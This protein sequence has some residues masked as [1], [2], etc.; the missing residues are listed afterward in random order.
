L[1]FARAP[2]PRTRSLAAS[3]AR[4]VKG[5]W[6]VSSYLA[7]ARFVAG[8]PTLLRA[9]EKDASLRRLQPTHDTSTLRAARFPLALLVLRDLAASPREEHA[10]VEPRLTA[11]LQL[12]RLRNP[13]DGRLRDRGPFV[14]DRIEHR[15]VLGAV[16]GGPSTLCLPP[17]ALSAARAHASSPLT[18]S[19][20]PASF[21]PDLSAK[22][23]RGQPPGPCFTAVPSRTTALP[24][25]ER[26]RSA[27]ARP[28]VLRGGAPSQVPPTSA[29]STACEH[30]HEPF[31]PR[32]PAG[33]ARSACAEPMRWRP[34]PPRRP[35]DPGGSASR[36]PPTVLADREERLALASRVIPSQGPACFR[37]PAPP[38]CAP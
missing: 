33:A 34:H 12:Q 36:P 26:L 25:P 37:S 7:C 13:P 23:S 15:V 19:V 18:S 10:R 22:L 16:I 6:V 31:D 28:C 38:G 3:P 30:N 1:L 17:A 20:A 29:T 2:S 21:A 9:G 35:Q 5:G 14:T 24:D 4:L 27:C 8:C 32:L 11:S